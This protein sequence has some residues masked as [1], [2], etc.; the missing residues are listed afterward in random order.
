MYAE[1]YFDREFPVT[2]VCPKCDVVFLGTFWSFQTDSMAGKPNQIHRWNDVQSDHCTDCSVI[3][4][5]FA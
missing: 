4:G 5:T 1:I 3:Y 2:L